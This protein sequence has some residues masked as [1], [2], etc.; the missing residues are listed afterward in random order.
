MANFDAI[1]LT[2]AKRYEQPGNTANKGNQVIFASCR[3]R[4]ALEELPAIQDSDPVKE[5]D[6]ASQADGSDNLCLRSKCANSKPNEQDSPDAQRESAEVDLPDKVTEPDGEEGREDGLGA[7]ISRARSITT[8]SPKIK[9]ELRKNAGS[10]G[11]A[12]R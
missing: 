9:K 4:H 6:Q 7:D 10:A 1:E 8:A 11:V 12:A 2:K 5:H 3:A